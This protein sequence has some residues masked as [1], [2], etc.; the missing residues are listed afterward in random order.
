M[1]ASDLY[2]SL[3]SNLADRVR[4]PFYG[5]FIISWI[6]INWKPILVFLLSKKNIYAVINDLSAYSDARY[7]LYYPVA[8]TLFLVFIMPVIAAIYSFFHSWVVHVSDSG[9]GFKNWLNEKSET[10]R[11]NK[12]E[13]IQKNHEERIAKA[14][15]AIAESKAKEDQARLISEM[16]L[17]DV[18]DLPS[19]KDELVRL[20][21][22]NTLLQ[23]SNDD[24]L[25][26]LKRLFSGEIPSSA[27]M[28][29]GL[30]PGGQ[31]QFH[32]E[33]EKMR[34]ERESKNKQPD[35]T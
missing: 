3:K 31:M 15:A 29:S 32:M 5:S 28:P 24:L 2:S 7:Q 16:S 19:L 10:K 17:R 35:D 12:L 27:H 25:Y 11:N 4:S 20:H 13:Y 6:V 30:R 23:K 33:A 9:T 1:S 22:A 18:A 14:D 8:A 34:L 21:Q 26:K